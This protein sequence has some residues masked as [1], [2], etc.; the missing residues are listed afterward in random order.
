[1]QND[2][3]HTYISDDDKYYYEKSLA[4]LDQ[5]NN[6]V[7]RHG[8]RCPCDTRNEDSSYKIILKH[9]KCISAETTKRPRVR[10]QHQAVVIFM[11]NLPWLPYKGKTMMTSQSLSRTT[12]MG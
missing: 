10:A 9:A 4:E 2:F 3:Y 12:K 7:Y 1:M 11:K 8:Y 5:G 6:K